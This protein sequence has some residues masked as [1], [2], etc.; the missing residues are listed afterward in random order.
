[1]EKIAA[2]LMLAVLVEGI[3]E[4]YGS[5]IP[6]AYKPYAAALLAVVVCVLYNADL[7]AA[8]GLSAGVPYVGSVLTGVII[9]R[10]SNYLNDFVSQVRSPA[11]IVVENTV[12]TEHA[13]TDE[14]VTE[15]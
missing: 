3:I 14:Q 12:T 1:M 4:H 2:L 13:V 10:G 15:G 7:L 6:S 11:P 8:L 9:G 5:A